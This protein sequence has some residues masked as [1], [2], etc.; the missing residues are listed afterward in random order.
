MK[1][2]NLLFY[3]L[4]IAAGCLFSCQKESDEVTIEENHQNQNTKLDATS[5]LDL[6][7]LILNETQNIKYPISIVLYD[8]T[9]DRSDDFTINNDNDFLA[10]LKAIDLSKITISVK[11]PMIIID[12][13]TNEETPLA[14]NLEL[15]K[16]V[17]KLELEKFL[18]EFI[19]QAKYISQLDGQQDDFIDGSPN[20]LIEYPY[21]VIIGD[22]TIEIENDDNLMSAKAA[23]DVYGQ[24]EIVFP[25]ITMDF[26]YNRFLDVRNLETIQDAQNV[27]DLE[28]LDPRGRFSNFKIQYPLFSTI[29]GNSGFASENIELYNTVSNLDVGS[30]IF[31][32]DY[33][34]TFIKKSDESTLQINNIEE[35]ISTIQNN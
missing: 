30:D 11:Y 13:Q 28:L 8:K 31:T 33:P 12:V 19:K 27:Y 20:I 23:Y 16:E 26:R 25:V 32:V 5:I 18:L 7:K 22:Q 15:D 3:C 17:E 35:F 21:S 6:E 34:I 9:T 29:N 1:Q 2:S 10:Y 24:V 14:N 4:L